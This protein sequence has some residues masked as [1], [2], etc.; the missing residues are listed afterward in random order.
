MKP[1]DPVTAH[2]SKPRAVLFDLDG[3]LLNT[4]DDLGDS[5]NRVLQ[6]NGFPQHPISAYKRFVGDG[7]ENLVRRAIPP[8][9]AAIETEVKRITEEMKREYKASWDVKTAPYPGIPEL[10]AALSERKVPAAV[11]TNKPHPLVSSILQRYFPGIRFAAAYGDRPGVPRKP[12]P[13]TALEIS[14]QIGIPPGEFLYL[15]D[16]DTDMKTASAAGMMP[17]GALWG[18]RDAEELVRA[19]AERLIAAPMEL[20]SLL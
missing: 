2:P 9:V 16:T 13:L 14:R 17:I 10:L 5:M 20:I 18:F 12:D 11:L 3:T 6:A 1:P 8:A 4:L 15:G 7:V 19:G